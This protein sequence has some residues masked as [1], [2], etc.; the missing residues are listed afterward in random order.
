MRSSCDV[1]ENAFAEAYVKPEYEVTS[2]TRL[3]KFNRNIDTNVE[4]INHRNAGQEHTSRT[5][6]WIV[7]LQGAFNPEAFT[8]ASSAGPP[9]GTSTPNSRRFE[10]SCSLR[11]PR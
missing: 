5:I 2:A 1:N 6:Y 3:P 7:Y 9:T 10:G 4:N 8:P 11:A